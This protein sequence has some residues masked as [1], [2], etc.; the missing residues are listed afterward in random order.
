MDL[1]QTEL[2][3]GGCPPESPLQ[4]IQNLCLQHWRSLKGFIGSE[5]AENPVELVHGSE[6]A[7]GIVAGLFSLQ[8]AGL[9][10]PASGGS[11]RALPAPGPGGIPLREPPQRGNRPVQGGMGTESLLLK[12][13]LT[14]LSLF[15]A[16]GRGHHR[17]SRSSSGS[18]D[19]QLL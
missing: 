11:V 2:R 19:A 7:D 18:D 12:G 17:I 1:T 14:R 16:A 9:S 10:T 15:C 3:E 6:P 13:F 4:R 8:A 5:P